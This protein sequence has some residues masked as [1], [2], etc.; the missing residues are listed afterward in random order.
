MLVTGCRCRGAAVMTWQRRQLS[1]G[2]RARFWA[3]A[4]T[5]G[6]LLSFLLARTLLRDLCSATLQR[7]AGAISVLRRDGV[8]YLS[9]ARAGVPS[10]DQSVGSR[11]GCVPPPTRSPARSHLPARSCYVNAGT[12]LSALRTSSTESLAAALARSP[13]GLP[14]PGSSSCCWPLASV[15]LTARPRRSTLSGQLIV[16]VLAPP[17]VTPNIA[18][19]VKARVP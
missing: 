15:R 2:G 14:S 12:Q 9:A 3:F 13:C 19:T 5:A 4:S 16:I 18:A 8:L 1:A 11:P 7:P 10:S 17:V 6:A